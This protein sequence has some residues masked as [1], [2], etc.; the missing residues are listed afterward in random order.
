MYIDCILIPKNEELISKE[1][2]EVLFEYLFDYEDSYI[3][4]ESRKLECKFR[5]PSNK[6]YCSVLIKIKGSGKEEADILSK[7]KKRLKH[8]NRS[9]NYELTLGMD[10]SSLYYSIKSYKFLAKYER[11]LRYLTY[12]TMIHA[13]GKGWVETSVKDN[14]N[15]RNE[16][17]PNR[18]PY[19]NTLEVFSLN[20]IRIYLFDRNPELSSGDFFKLVDEYSRNEELGTDEKMD[21][22]ICSIEQYKGK[23]IWEKYFNYDNLQYV[24]DSFERIRK[25]RNAVMH[26]H[27]IS[28]ELS[29]IHI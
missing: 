17:K 14:K 19:E 6:K 22:I 18:V 4:I 26:H 3:K 15:I 21:N 5:I 16:I 28:K 24:E 29:L 10:E 25:Y 2:I 1:E 20:L 9:N 8:T 12:L 27:T 7:C 11:N 23:S 13:H